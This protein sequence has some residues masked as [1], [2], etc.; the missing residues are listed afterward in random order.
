MCRGQVW[1]ARWDGVE[2]DVLDK[3]LVTLDSQHSVH[4]YLRSLDKSVT[5]FYWRWD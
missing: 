1:W 3:E 5:G 4:R 2:G